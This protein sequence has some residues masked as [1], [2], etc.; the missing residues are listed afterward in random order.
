MTPPLGFRADLARWRQLVAPDWIAALVAGAPVEAAPPEEWRLFEVGCD[1]L[2]AFGNGHIPGAGYLDTMRFEHGPLW[3][4]VDDTTLERLLCEL[5]IRHDTTV[6]L[7]GRNPL[8]AAR[9]AHLLLYA[10]VTD[11]RLLDGGF[12]AWRRAGLA[13]EAGPGRCWPAVARFGATLPMRREYLLNMA[14]TRALPAHGD[15]TLA[16]IRTRAEYLGETSGYS[17]IDARGDIP[18]A[19]WGQAGADGDVNSMSAYQ[20]AA[21]CMKPASEIAAMWEAGGIVPGRRTVFYCG[22]G[23]RASLAFFYAWLMGWEHIAVFDGGWCEWSR[24]PAN[25]VVCR[26]SCPPPPSSRSGSSRSTCCRA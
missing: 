20:D 15:A 11:V 1:D 23:W 10:G 5:G 24:D 13:L 3:N 19:L 8:A 17:Y 7:V 22:T 14:A 26:V 2:D 25:P 9:V 18:G 12:D 6:V 21:G 4:K 16:S